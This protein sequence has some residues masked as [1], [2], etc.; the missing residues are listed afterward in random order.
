MKKLLIVLL[1]ALL[2]LSLFAGCGKGGETKNTKT[3]HCDN[4]G[5]EVTVDADSNQNDDWILYCPECEKALGLDNI[6]PSE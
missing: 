2:I 3:L 6:I 4:C 1:S 5:K